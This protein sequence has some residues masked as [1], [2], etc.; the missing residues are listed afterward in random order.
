LPFVLAAFVEARELAHK[1]VETTAGGCKLAQRK[2]GKPARRRCPQQQGK[3]CEI[4][5]L[6]ENL[7]KISHGSAPPSARNTA[8]TIGEKAP[9]A[10]AAGATGRRQ[11]FAGLAATQRF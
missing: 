6:N 5:A 4:A 11:W 2:P 1:V 8:N 3:V 10:T 9:A 7:E